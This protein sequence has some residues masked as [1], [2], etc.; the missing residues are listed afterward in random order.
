M[1]SCRIE[2]V[3]A[4]KRYSQPFGKGR[5]LEVALLHAKENG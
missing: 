5:E 1:L 2:P 4:G 3:H